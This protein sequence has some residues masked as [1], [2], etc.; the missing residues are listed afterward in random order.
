MKRENWFPTSIWIDDLTEFS[1]EELDKLAAKWNNISTTE[2]SKKKS[3]I[4]GWQSK[5][6]FITDVDSTEL[7]LFNIIN[8]KV[9]IVADEAS[10][11]KQKILMLDNWW[12]NINGKGN[13]NQVHIHPRSLISGVF[14][15]QVP[16]GPSGDLMF[17][18]SHDEYFLLTNTEFN[19]TVSCVRAQ[20]KP[21]KG[22]LMLFLSCTQHEVGVNETNEKRMSVSFNYSW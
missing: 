13:Y 7:K 6:L 15:V 14:Y 20:Y 9:Q 8:Q 17:P 18:R 4:G 1:D 2:P 16:E 12:V 11:R 22:R 19:S 3:N 5:N 21:R 10:F